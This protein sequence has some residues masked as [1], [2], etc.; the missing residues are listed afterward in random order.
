MRATLNDYV[1][2]PFRAFQRNVWLCI[3]LVGLLMAIARRIPLLIRQPLR[4][5]LL[6]FGAKVCIC[7][8]KLIEKVLRPLVVDSGSE[9]KLERA[10]ALLR[11]HNLLHRPHTIIQESFTRLYYSVRE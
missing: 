3:A 7:L 8:S 5:T 11:L 4:T 1:Y 10:I 9:T 2:F 6:A